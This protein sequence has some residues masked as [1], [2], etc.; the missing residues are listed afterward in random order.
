M[1]QHRGI[2]NGID[3]AIPGLPNI[4][5]FKGLA[6]AGADAA[7]SLGGAAIIQTIFGN[8]WGIF[9]EFGVPILLSDNVLGISYTNTSSISNAPIEKG[10]FTSYNKVQD[11]RSAIVQLSKGSGGALE[12]GAWLAQ[13]EVLANSTLTYNIISPEFVYKSMNITGLS[14]ARTA[15]DGKQLIKANI[16][17]E[18]VREV[19][20]SYAVEQVANPD[21]AASKDG[22]EVQ[23]KDQSS[24]T[25]VLKRIFG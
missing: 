18:E 6:T 23:P 25:S 15:E 12:R 11:P 22:G 8:V 17:L 3:M 16:T 10:S 9:N 1:P 7:I 21:D 4:P 13:L 2:F 5:N 19:T 20:F 24:N 14:Y